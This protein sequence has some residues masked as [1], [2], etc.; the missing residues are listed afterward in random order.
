MDMYLL[1]DDMRMSTLRS[2]QCKEM[3]D[4][5]DLYN[6]PDSLTKQAIYRCLE[7]LRY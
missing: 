2:L 6:L 5:F 7:A 4:Q 1:Q 3:K